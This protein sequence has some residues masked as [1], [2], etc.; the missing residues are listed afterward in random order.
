MVF[1]IKN[2]LKQFK[3]KCKKPRNFCHKC[4][5]VFSNEMGLKRHYKKAHYTI[6]PSCPKKEILRH[7]NSARFHHLK[8]PSLKDVANM[9]KT[10]NN[11]KLSKYILNSKGSENNFKV[12]Q[13]RNLKNFE[14]YDYMTSL[15]LIIVL[16]TCFWGSVGSYINQVVVQ[17]YKTKIP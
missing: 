4:Q 15:L 2:G 3:H 10:S 11:L 17:F 5:L 1:P 12:L 6:Y 14:K 16:N 7:D 13:V 9:N 8:K